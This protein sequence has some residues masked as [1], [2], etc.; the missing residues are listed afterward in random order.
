MGQRLEVITSAELRKRTR[1]LCIFFWPFAALG[2]VQI[3]HD[4]RRGQRFEDWW[5]MIPVTM[6]VAI[7]PFF[8]YL[9]RGKEVKLFDER[10]VTTRSG[11][12]FAWDRFVRVEDYKRKRMHNHYEL[13]FQDGTAV[14]ADLMADNFHD[15]RD[16]VAELQAGTNRFLR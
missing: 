14:V 9:G 2:I 5:W 15:L 3:V 1:L 16:V 6:M 4:V 12:T 7:G 8:L 10:G 11:R 13:H